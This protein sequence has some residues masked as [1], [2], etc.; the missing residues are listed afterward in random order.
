[1]GACKILPSVFPDRMLSIEKT[2]RNS[3]WGSQSP[4]DS[5]LKF[6]WEKRHCKQ[7]TALMQKGSEVGGLTFSGL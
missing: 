2:C 3:V 5:F 4:A 6:L 1:M 7:I